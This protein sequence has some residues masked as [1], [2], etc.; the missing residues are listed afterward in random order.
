MTYTVKIVDAEKIGGC[1]LVKEFRNASQDLAT[2]Y[3]YQ[4]TF[5]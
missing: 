5:K 3:G 2:E 1:D 4:S